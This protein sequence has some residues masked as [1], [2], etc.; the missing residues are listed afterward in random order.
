MEGLAIREIP[1]TF[2]VRLTESAR[3]DLAMIADRLHI[4]FEE[5]LSRAVGTL[6]VLVEQ[7]AAGGEVIL[8]ARNGTKQVLPV[9]EG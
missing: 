1:E 9:R 5:V 6:A 2:T 8:K 7:D 4:P 3:R